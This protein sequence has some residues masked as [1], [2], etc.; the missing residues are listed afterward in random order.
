MTRAKSCFE[1]LDNLTCFQCSD[2]MSEEANILIQLNK[3]DK[4]FN[5]ELFQ[6][7]SLEL[8]EEVYKFH[9]TIPGYSPTPL[10][11]L[12]YLAKQLKVQSI[13]VKDESKR[14]GLNAYKFLG[15]SYSL[16][17]QL[18]KHNKPGKTEKITQYHFFLMPRKPFHVAQM[19]I[20]P[21][22]L[23]RKQWRK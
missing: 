19:M 9:Q 16:G 22:D 2:K 10:V 4:D 21:G 17:K 8:A 12:G 23:L 20:F 6:D 18:L 11:N 7:F 15:V 14:F 5:H 1:K 13:H 3:F